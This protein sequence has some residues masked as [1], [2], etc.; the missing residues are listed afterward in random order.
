[1]NQLEKEHLQKKAQTTVSE[2]PQKD[3]IMVH[4]S[5][6]LC[7]APFESCTIATD[8]QL[9]VGFSPHDQFFL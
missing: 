4:L 8:S 3:H 2:L 5:M 1:M 7:S 9:A 6:F